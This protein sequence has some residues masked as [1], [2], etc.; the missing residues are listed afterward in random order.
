V[1]RRRLTLP[2]A[3]RASESI[4]VDTVHGSFNT[5]STQ[6]FSAPDQ[7]PPRRPYR[8]KEVVLEVCAGSYQAVI[9]TL[10]FFVFR[11]VVVQLRLLGPP[12]F[13]AATTTNPNS[14]VHWPVLAGSIPR[15]IRLKN[16]SQQDW[17][18]DGFRSYPD[19]AIDAP[20]SSGLTGRIHYVLRR[21]YELGH[22]YE[23]DTSDQLPTLPVC[24]AALNDFEPLSPLS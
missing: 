20:N 1:G 11:P 12:E 9:S 15:F 3:V 18:T 23:V 5:G 7:I 16:N 14:A 19:C 24:K 10:N 6:P 4:I 17:F 8:I 21:Y 13:G 2:S 22:E